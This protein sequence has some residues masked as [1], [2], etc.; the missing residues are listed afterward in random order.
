LLA[1]E[2]QGQVALDFYRRG[3]QL[4]HG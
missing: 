1:A 2:D 3:Y 4:L